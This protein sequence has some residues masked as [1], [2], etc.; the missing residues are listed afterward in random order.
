MSC[1]RLVKLDERL[2]TLITLRSQRYFDNYVP[3]TI[4]LSGDEPQGVY[5]VAA[6][7]T[8]D[9]YRFE[10]RFS[11]ANTAFAFKLRYA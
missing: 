1:E 3:I 7:R 6:V 11:D 8:V 5:H 2:A 9:E 10:F 4:W